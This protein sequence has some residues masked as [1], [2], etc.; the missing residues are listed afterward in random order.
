V[1]QVDVEAT[2]RGTAIDAVVGLAATAP[3]RFTDLAAI[4]R[5]S[6]AG[7]IDVRDG[8]ASVQ[9]PSS[10]GTYSVT[11]VDTGTGARTRIATNYAFRTEPRG[12]TSLGALGQFVDGT[13]GGV[14]IAFVLERY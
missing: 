4:A 3:T 14:S 11:V 13:T 10:T 9:T 12:T 2:P 8:S 6:P 5:F 1:L 7:I